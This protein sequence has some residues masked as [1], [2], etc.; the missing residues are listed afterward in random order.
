MESTFERVW[1]DDI[2]EQFR[3]VLV[4]DGLPTQVYEIT[5]RNLDSNIPLDDKHKQP[6]DSVINSLKQFAE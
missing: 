2:K 3:V 1:A 4:R 5:V 6:L